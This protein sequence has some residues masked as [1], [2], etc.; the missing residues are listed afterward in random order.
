MNQYSTPCRSNVT[1]SILSALFMGIVLVACEPQLSHKAAF[2]NEMSTLCKQILVGESVFPDDSTHALYGA[3]LAAEFVSCTDTEI[4]IPF[5]VNDDKS[6]TWILTLSDKGLLFKHDH[7]HAD[8]S[9]DTLTNYGGWATDAGSRFTQ[10]FPADAETGALIPEAITNVWTF[11][12][13]RD[14]GTFTYFLE[15]HGKPRYRAEFKL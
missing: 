6:R 15:R 5:Q 7:R 13:D 9:P 12:I 3:A 10:S 1:K 4:R 14:A 11:T 2:F 8:G